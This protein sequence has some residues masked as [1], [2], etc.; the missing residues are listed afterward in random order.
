[1]YELE[2]RAVVEKVKSV[3]RRIADQL[4]EFLAKLRKLRQK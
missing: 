3:V 1:M 2:K 4:K